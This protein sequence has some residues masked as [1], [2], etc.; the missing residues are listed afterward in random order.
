[1]IDIRAFPQ[2]G[3]PVYHISSSPI[4]PLLDRPIICIHLPQKK[5]NGNIKR[6]WNLNSPLELVQFFRAMKCKPLMGCQFV[7]KFRR[8]GVPK[9]YSSLWRETI[10]LISGQIIGQFGKG[11]NTW[12]TTDTT[13]L[14]SDVLC[15]DPVQHV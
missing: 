6:F 12:D 15:P 3:V 10:F 1:M 14:F 5:Q 9:V 13:A 7:P 11:K 4:F 2:A 8:A